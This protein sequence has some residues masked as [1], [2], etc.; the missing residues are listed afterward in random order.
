MLHRLAMSTSSAQSSVR[1]TL[2]N[3]LK[4]ESSNLDHLANNLPKKAEILVKKIIET[5]GKII[6]SGLGKSGLVA[7]KLAATFSSTGTPALFVHPVEA[8]HGD[9]GVIQQNDFLIIL[10]KSAAGEE[11]EKIISFLANQGNESALLC[12]N[13]GPLVHKANLVIQLPITKEACYLNLAPTTSST[14]MMAFGDALAITIAQQRGFTK[15]DFA[16]LHPAGSLGKKLILL[17]A[18]IMHRGQ[19]LPLI[20]INTPFPEILVTITQKKMGVGIVTDDQQRLLGIITDGDLRRACKSGVEVFEQKAHNIMT[21]NPKNISSDMLAREALEYMEHFNIT[22][23]TVTHEKKIIGL[24]HI[25][26]L[27]KAGLQG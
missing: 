14:L 27:I 15:Q 9:L 20:N 4:T 3:V 12:C 2:I 10:S 21:P 11:I 16:R 18:D 1:N 7:H 17:V 23:L 13:S 26:D 8:L 5:K 25:H 6:F 24:L 19:L 22:T